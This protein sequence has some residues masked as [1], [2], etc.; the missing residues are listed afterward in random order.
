MLLLLSNIAL[1]QSNSGMFLNEILNEDY[2]IKKDIKS[3]FVK[4]DISPL[5]TETENRFIFGFIGDNY[6]RIRIKLISV[7][8]NKDKPFQYFVYGKSMVKNNICEF[9]GTLT[10]TN[11]YDFNNPEYDEKRHGKITGEYLFYE[12]SQQKHTGFFKG[13]FSSAWYINK[14]GILKYDDIM[15]VADGF[16]NNKFVGIW[17]SYNGGRAKPCNWGDHRIP[18]SGDLDVGT[19]EF[20][21]NE[22]YLANGWSG[23]SQAYGGSHDREKALTIELSQWWH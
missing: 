22:K 5:M 7:I 6:Q 9:Q 17:T 19:G 12:N 10:V 18:N 11:I 21:P 23:Y 20:A 13:V 16:S 15:G 4:Y 14:D 8:R 1:A 3:E 2:I